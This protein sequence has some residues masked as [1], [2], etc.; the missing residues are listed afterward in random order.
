MRSL[1]GEDMRHL[2]VQHVPTGKLAHPLGMTAQ[3][4][5]S[6]LLGTKLHSCDPLVKGDPE[7]AALSA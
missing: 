5:T 3:L 7:N 6:G 2:P 1:A 4:G